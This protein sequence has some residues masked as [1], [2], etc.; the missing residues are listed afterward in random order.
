MSH[1]GFQLDFDTFDLEES[2]TCSYDSLTVLADVEGAEELG[3][4]E[5]KAV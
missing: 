1:D 2:D 3:G 5:N 4:R